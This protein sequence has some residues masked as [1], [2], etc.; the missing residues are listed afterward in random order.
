MALIQ[1]TDTARTVASVSSN[2]DGQRRE[3]EI[4]PAAR[5]HLF[6]RLRLSNACCWRFE[7]LWRIGCTWC[8]QDHT[9]MDHDPETVPAF[10]PLP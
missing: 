6:H 1:P 10:I 8:G 7:Q 2:R 3:T 9:R 4:W 5:W